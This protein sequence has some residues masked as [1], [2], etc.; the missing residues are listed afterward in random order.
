M[1]VLILIFINVAVFI[2]PFVVN[3]TGASSDSFLNYISLG[4]KSNPEIRD[5]EYYRLLTS[6]F[7]HAGVTHLLLNML[8][9]YNVGPSVLAIYN[10]NLLFLIIYLVSGITGSLFSFFFNPG[11]PSLGASGAIMGLVGALLAY[12]ILFKDY[13]TLQIILINIVIIFGLGLSDSRI[14]NYGHLGGLICGFLLGAFFIVFKLI[15]TT[16]S[17]I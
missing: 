5:G 15:P 8:S 3:F 6:N 14:D 13:S 12:A 7:L 4:W 10:S 17:L 2:L 9:L 1:V 11:V 16:G